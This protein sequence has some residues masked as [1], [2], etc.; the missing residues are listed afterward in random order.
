MIFDRLP[1]YV[2]P[3][4]LA[5][6]RLVRHNRPLGHPAF[7]SRAGVPLVRPVTIPE[8][9]V[10]GEIEKTDLVRRRLQ[11]RSADPEAGETPR[12]PEPQFAVDTFHGGTVCRF[13]HPRIFVFITPTFKFPAKQ[14]LPLALVDFI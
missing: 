2:R 13:V 3:V 5:L 6:Q 14:R 1:H 10:K 12:A 4:E 7:D 8:Q 9:Q 11:P